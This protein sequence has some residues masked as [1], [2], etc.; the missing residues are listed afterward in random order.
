MTQD[1]RPCNHP[2]VGCPSFS[3]FVGA[4]YNAAIYEQKD[5]LKLLYQWLCAWEGTHLFSPEQP[6]GNTCT[7]EKWPELDNLPG[8]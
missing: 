3:L 8:H 1:S 7:L 4:A 6:G 2:C 5:L